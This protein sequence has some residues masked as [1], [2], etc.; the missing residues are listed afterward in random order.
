[1]IDWWCDMNV[2][3]DIK[4]VELVVKTAIVYTSVPILINGIARSH[5][6]RCLLTTYTSRCDFQFLV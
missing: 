5:L 2:T 3:I 1:M 6:W 4:G